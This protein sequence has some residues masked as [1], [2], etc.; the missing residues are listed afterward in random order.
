MLRANLKNDFLLPSMCW[1]SQS[2]SVWN[3]TCT[4][5]G[6]WC[7]SYWRVRTHSPASMRTKCLSWYGL[8][9]CAYRSE[10]CVGGVCMFARR[11]LVLECM[12][13]RYRVYVCQACSF[14]CRCLLCGWTYMHERLCGRA[15]AR[16][17][18]RMLVIVVISEW[19][20]VDKQGR[21]AADTRRRGATGM[22]RVDEALLGDTARWAAHST[23]GPARA[24]AV[25]AAVG[26][27]RHS[28]SSSYERCKYKLSYQVNI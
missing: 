23:R 20:R 17:G 28:R 13:R 5:S 1:H 8:A 10:L 6:S 12:S 4:R 24:D 11:L 9:T 21:T 15:C 14:P 22:G 19:L 26:P 2:H 25:L 27:V 16:V 18:V 7:G 3:R